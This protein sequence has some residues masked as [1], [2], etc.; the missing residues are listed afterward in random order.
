MEVVEGGKER[1]TA[2]DDDDEKERYTIAI[3]P[4]VRA[5]E[6]VCVCISCK[7]PWR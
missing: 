3:A 5:Q 4:W 2:P 1:A 6:L 7:Q